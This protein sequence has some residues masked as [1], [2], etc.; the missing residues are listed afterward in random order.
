M[1]DANASIPTPEP[2]YY[3]PMFGAKGK[4]I[5][6]TSVTFNLKSSDKK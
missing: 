4:A 1:G 6:S 5:Y 2:V 3:R